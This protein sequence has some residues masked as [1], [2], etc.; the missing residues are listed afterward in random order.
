[1]VI[2]GSTSDR[3]NGAAG[4]LLPHAIDLAKAVANGTSNGTAHH[5][6]E[7]S[8]ADVANDTSYY[9]ASTGPYSATDDINKPITNGIAKQVD[10]HSASKDRTK[11]TPNGNGANGFHVQ[12]EPKLVTF[13]AMDEDGLK[14]LSTA[15]N[16]Y[17]SRKDRPEWTENFLSKLAYTLNERRSS[18]IWRSFAVLNSTSDLQHQGLKLSRSV[19]MLSKP[20]LAFCFTGQGAQWYAMGKELFSYPV[21][22][23]SMEDM[24]AYLKNLGCSWS[25]VDEIHRDKDLSN[26]N[27]P[28][29]SQPLCSAVQI[30]LVDLLRIFQVQPT[31]VVGHSSGEI[32][33]AYCVGALDRHSAIKVAYY[34]GTLTGRLVESGAMSGG[35][36]SVGLSE[37]E[38]KDYL[39]KVMSK[40]A[41]RGIS[42][43]CINSPRNVTITGHQD[44][45]EALKVLLDEE[46]IFARRLLVN[47]A[48][49]SSYL[50]GLSDQYMDLMGQLSG[51]YLSRCSKATMISSVT[52][53]VVTADELCQG[54]Y[55][56]RNLLSPVR[57]SEA[58]TFACVPSTQP[59]QKGVSENAQ[60]QIDDI[61]EIGPHSA[62]QGPIRETMKA[63]NK[64]KPMEYSSAL[65]RFVS[66]TESLLEALG[67]LSCRGHSIELSEVNHN[68]KSHETPGLLADLPEYPF[69]HS[70]SYWRESRISQ[71]HRFRKALRNDSLGIPVPD[72]S[73]IEAR[74]R[75][76]IRLSDSPWLEDHKVGTK[77]AP[78]KT[79]NVL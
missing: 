56:V 40:F 47:V 12:A 48:Y 45:I 57:F 54:R 37:T 60:L 52:A 31:T 18:L 10:S 2:N 49:H 46:N 29:Y 55:W 22:R 74:W 11:C 15:Y 3:A 28:A 19:R 61:L 16:K 62:L 34:R 6:G 78:L 65:V 63:I 42:V 25:L 14:R 1:M 75:R 33:A 59:G 17:L 30:A 66:G 72:W 50:K 26:V 9:T 5:V 38:V 71:G 44:Q 23:E 4:S 20:R 7:S 58:L 24:D 27:K 69:D 13:S 76:R 70:R 36:L 77:F 8:V 73:P 53:D 64:T 41:H 79:S 43:G 39:E 51:Q 68:S 32:A 67:R 35:M 21:F